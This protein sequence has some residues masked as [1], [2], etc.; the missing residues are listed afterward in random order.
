MKQFAPPHV[1]PATILLID[2]NRHGS[3]ARKIA[4]EQQGHKVEV[5]STI[6][7]GLASLE[8]GQF[9]LVVTQ[10]RV[11]KHPA[12][13]IVAGLRAVRNGILVVGV[14]GG[15]EPSTL[16][17]QAGADEI[18]SKGPKETAQLQRA[19]ERL[20]TRPAKRPP[21]KQTARPRARAKS[22]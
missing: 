10:L 14:A 3:V 20:L 15:V 12:A 5:A 11:P 4:L 13:E 2:P 19:V 6:D 22:V 17:S 21:V 1:Q 16:E 9:D 18:V 8:N 7:E